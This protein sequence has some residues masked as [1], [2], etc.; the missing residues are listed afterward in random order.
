MKIKN[1]IKK[2]IA[3]QNREKTEKLTVRFIKE[4]LELK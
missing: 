4:R 3:M 1:V 2:G